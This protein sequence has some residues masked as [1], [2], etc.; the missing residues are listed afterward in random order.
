MSRSWLSLDIR[1]SC[2]GSVSSFHVLCLMI[3]SYSHKTTIMEKTTI[4]SER[5]FTF[6]FRSLYAI[7]RLSV[8]CL[9]S[10]CL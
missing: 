1:M 2:L 8:V 4:F 7:A 9:S 10:V 3:V 5:E 6:T